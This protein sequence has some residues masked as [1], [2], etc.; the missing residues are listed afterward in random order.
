MRYRRVV[1]R[2]FRG[3]AE[4]VID[5]PDG[6]LLVIEGPNEAGKSSIVEAI[7]LLFEFTAES[8]DQRVQSVRPEGRD[9]DPEVELEFTLGGQQCR[10]RKVFG[11][12]GVTELKVAGATARQ[13]TGRE[14][15]NEAKQL[16][17]ASVDRALLRALRV[18]QGESLAVPEGLDGSPVL[19]RA[20]DAA[21][22]ADPAGENLFTRSR[23]EYLRYYTAERA[24][25]TGEL[26]E[27]R[28]ARDEAA[29]RVD[30]LEQRLRALERKAERIAELEPELAALTGSIAALRERAQQ[31]GALHEQRQRAEQEARLLEREAE[32]AAARLSGL[33]GEVRRRAER[34]A[35]IERL[36][37][38]LQQTEAALAERT[39]ELAELRAGEAAAR[40]HAGAA[41]EALEAAERRAAAAAGDY[42]HLQDVLQVRQMERRLAD[43]RVAAGRRAEAE[44]FLAGCRINPE[45][46]R[47]IEQASQDVG[48]TEAQL[49]LVAVQVEVEGPA[50]ARVFVDGE[51]QA[52]AAGLLRV[53]VTEER[54]IDLPGGFA[55]VV[56]P[57]QSQGRLETLLEER[58][59][60]VARLLAEAGAASVE[61]AGEL[62]RRRVR[63]LDTR[64][65]AEQ[66]IQQA[67]MDLRDAADLEG[68]LERTRQRVATYR[69]ENAGRELPESMEEARAA[70][71]AGEEERAKARRAAEAAETVHREA[72]ARVDMIARELAGLEAQATAVHGRLVEL[73]TAVEATEKERPTAELEVDLAAQR[74]EVTRVQQALVAA[75]EQLASVPDTGRE[76]AEV[77]SRREVAERQRREIEQELDEARGALKHEG[78]GTLQSELDLAR[79]ALVEAQTRFDQVE[80]RARAAE[81]LYRTLERHR[82]EARAAYRPLLAEQIDALGRRVFGEDFGVELDD[83]LAI[84][85]RRL[86]GV[87]LEFGKLSVGAREQLAV[88][89]RAACA[90]VAAEDGVPFFLDDAL[91]W[92]D[93]ER[94][95]ELGGLL[96]E[97]AR[98][99]QV[100]VL[101]CQPGRFAGAQPAEVVRI[102]AGRTGPLAGAASSAANQLEPFGA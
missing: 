90:A 49:R 99:V 80:R 22:A 82:K 1:I 17:D 7:E 94:L 73:R 100:V 97:L 52:L 34:R 13:L 50:G 5:F 14:A 10:Y 54:R 60:E 11:R 33:E 32:T 31:L 92:S 43:I 2:D 62:E 37:G 12:R 30:G 8:S 70:Q 18:P 29:R 91:G 16:L 48:R 47:A 89:Y 35:E 71:S 74:G 72:A 98:E 41:R 102:V 51:A 23:L 6:R 42:G 63:A 84:G 39:R 88:I 46:L 68:R 77:Q 69:Q 57:S 28:R 66:A 58:R 76:L 96:A 56:R 25:E 53:E 86:D 79:G 44:A 78:E 4:A 24:Q 101:T 36:T 81:L 38:E 93:E 59:A 9:A 83:R 61:E 85:G 40:D 87:S 15:H 95:G 20:L 19:Q 67:L 65:A 75:K 64:G 3:I 45:L 27:A 26:R 55:V 21:S